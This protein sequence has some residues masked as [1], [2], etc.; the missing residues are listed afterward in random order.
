MTLPA[1]TPTGDTPVTMPDYN[2]IL[3]GLT[4]V[5]VSAVAQA[6]DTGAGDMLAS[7]VIDQGKARAP[8]APLKKKTP[9]MAV[10]GALTGATVYSRPNGATM[11]MSWCFAKHV[12]AHN[13][14]CST[15]RQVAA[16]LR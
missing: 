16:R 12:K 4:D 14:C 11:T 3:P 8:R 7:H 15:V 9:V 10:P 1:P 2:A 6:F 5:L 13:M